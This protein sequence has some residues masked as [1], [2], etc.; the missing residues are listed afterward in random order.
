MAPTI[1]KYTLLLFLML[2]LFSLAQE[3]L[4]RRLEK[5]LGHELHSIDPDYSIQPDSSSLKLIY[6][7]VK[8]DQIIGLRY[9]DEFIDTTNGREREA[10]LY[11][12]YIT[13]ACITKKDF[14]E[15]RNW[16]RDSIA[17]ENLYYGLSEPSAAITWLNASD[18]YYSESQRIY[19]DVDPRDRNLNRSLFSLDWEKKLYYDDLEYIPLLYDMYLPPN[20]IFSKQ[21]G[22]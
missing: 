11:P 16:I 10:I 8:V 18:K 9:G 5:R 6:S 20:Q 7:R 3:K 2:P 15:F 12:T 21:K 17:R 13:D 14:L 19:R 1:M 22:A 4:V